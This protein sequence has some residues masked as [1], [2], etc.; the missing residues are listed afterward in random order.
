MSKLILIASILI[1]INFVFATTNDDDKQVPPVLNFEMKSLTGQDVDLS[2]YQGKVL[3]IVN[4]A[5][6][7]GYT[8]QYKDLEAVYKQYRDRG[9]EVLGFPANNFKQQE[10]GTDQQIAE[11][12][13]KN[14]GVTFPMFSKVSVL[15]DDQSPLFRYLTANAPETGDIKWNFEKF[16]IGRDG[17]IVARYRSKAIPSSDEVTQAIEAELEKK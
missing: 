6:K 9:F 11:F 10:P 5:S 8:P 2:Q 12:C 13:E 4:T 15:G 16:L 1:T 14:F 17:K 3:L 7:C